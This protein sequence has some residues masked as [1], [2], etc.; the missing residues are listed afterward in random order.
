VSTATY[1]P[2][3][4]DR[5]EQRYVG[6]R[7]KVTMDDI[8][9]AITSSFPEVFARL[10]R[11][12]VEPAGPPFVRYNVI[13]MERQLEIEVGIPVES[14]IPDNGRV[15]AGILPAGRY[16]TL[17]HIGDY[18]GLVAA[19]AALQKWAADNRLRFAMEETPNPENWETD[20]SYLLADP[21]R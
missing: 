5:G 10:E 20:V 19:N 9:D 4:I 16:A 1:E 2:R 6:I 15:V 12:G 11:A 14:P 8:G 13:D 21:E 18:S 7:S 17:T 3:I